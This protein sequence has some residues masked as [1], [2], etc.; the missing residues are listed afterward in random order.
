[1]E[2]EE[3]EK[4]KK[5]KEKEEHSFVG[6]MHIPWLQFLFWLLKSWDKLIFKEPSKS[7]SVVYFE[8]SVILSIYKT[9][10]TKPRQL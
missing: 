3:I 9:R 2:E 6:I 4:K 1:M 8:V 5:K 7:L 10:H